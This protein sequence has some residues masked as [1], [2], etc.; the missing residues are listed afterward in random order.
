[1]MHLLVIGSG[2]REHTLAWKL[3]SSPRVDRLSVAPGNGGTAAIADNVPIPDG[4]VAGLV[5]FAQR[6]R[7]DLAVVG[8][9]VPLVA[10]VVDAL[11]QAGLRAFGPV[12]AAARLEGSK[13]FAKR[14]M[15]EEGIPT[16]PAAI[17]TGY[18]EA[19]AY[20]AEQSAP[21]VIKASGLAA[22]KGV[23]IC[24]SLDEAERALHEVM[25][26]RV[27]GSAGDEVLIE[28]CLEGEEVSLLA[29][30]DGRTV[31]PM[32][33]ARDY[34]RAGEND[35]GPNTGGMGCFAPSPCLDSAQIDAVVTRIL[36]P[37]V[38]GLRR[39]GTPYIGV[40]YAGLMITVQGMQ[41]LEFNCRFGDPETQVIL[42]LLASD[43]VDVIEACLDG[44]LADE[45]IH[46][47]DLA[48]ACVVLASGGYPGAYETGHEI[49]GVAQ[50]EAIPDVA[51]FHAGTR[52]QD[53]RLVTAGGR[54]LA[55]MGTGPRLAVA[56]ERAYAAA[57]RIDFQGRTY[58]HDIGGSR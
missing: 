39:R 14:L 21:I 55:T 13:A 38:D 29:F 52:Q 43:L 57:E 8:P 37:A 22:G 58:R 56:L 7:V 5:A 40:L 47:R 23:L 32:P 11:N 30:C 15:I 44:R 16:A 6:E 42:P 25:V 4:D 33:P 45:P 49:R 53:G 18:R 46:W 24:S 10:G 54:V 48:A 27:F 3:A 17:L 34:K 19:Q 31:V 20:L 1:M 9:E 2:G 50:A 41:V 51:V 28:T 12:A 26:E 36:Q 35:V